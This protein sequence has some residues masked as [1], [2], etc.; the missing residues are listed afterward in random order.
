MLNN[1]TDVTKKFEKNAV[2][3]EYNS[4]VIPKI[5]EQEPLSVN[6]ENLQELNF[7][8]SDTH[9]NKLSDK[10]TNA[11]NCIKCNK[12][13]IYY[14]QNNSLP[15]RVQPATS[16]NVSISYI[17]MPDFCWFKHSIA[18][19]TSNVFYVIQGAGVTKSEYG[20]IYWNE[21]D[22]FV[23]PACKSN[24]T[25]ESLTQRE[26]SNKETYL[27]WANDG[28]ILRYLG[29]KCE[30]P[31]FEPVVY[32][33]KSILK[34]LNSNDTSENKSGKKR[35]STESVKEERNNDKTQQPNQQPN[36][37]RNGV[38]LSN[39]YMTNQNFNT[40]T[41]S[42]WSL[43]NTIGPSCVQKPHRHNSVAL[44]YCVFEGSE[45]EK[46]QVYTLMGK[47]LNDDGTIKDPQK[48]VWKK[49]GVFI[50]PPGWWHSHVNES[51]S[52]AYVF[53]IQDAGIHT[54]MNTLDIQFVD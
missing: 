28:P 25:H 23:L 47:E 14:F 5:P 53:P 40:L 33:K 39:P 30:A 45:K 43:Y 50:T 21:G 10:L 26:F 52:H 38:L 49:G 48:L 2:Y 6:L 34:A 29:A 9:T 13:R 18:N 15:E 19:N 54:Y 11:L 32:S 16:P 24:I 3:L 46:G 36:A 8:T 42:L 12:A 37:N 35:A 44:D 7:S 17:E 20:N 4:N 31:L 51:S 27:L 22:I 1:N 41:P